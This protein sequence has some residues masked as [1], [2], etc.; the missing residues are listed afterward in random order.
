[1]TIKFAIAFYAIY[2][3]IILFAKLDNKISTTVGGLNVDI[4]EPI[5]FND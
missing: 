2:H 1:M 5:I 4:T 3:V